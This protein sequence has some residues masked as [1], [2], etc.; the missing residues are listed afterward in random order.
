MYDWMN[1][2]AGLASWAQAFGAVAAIFGAAYLGSQQIKSNHQA[3]EKEKA[4]KAGALLAVYASASKNCRS[5]SELLFELPALNVLSLRWKVHIK[6]MFETNL[7]VIEGISAQDLVKYEF[8]VSHTVI[9][10]YMR[11]IRDLV[12]ELVELAESAE[13]LATHRPVSGEIKIKS[14]IAYKYGQ[15]SEHNKFV[16]LAWDE[17]KGAYKEYVRDLGVASELEK[18]ERYR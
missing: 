10:A 14:S 12:C 5:L 11:A 7:H 1:G 16:Q 17:Y 18:I 4:L 9:H 15:I 13:D 8:M 3:I 6:R 2:S